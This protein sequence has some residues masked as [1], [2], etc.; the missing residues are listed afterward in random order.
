MEHTPQDDGSDVNYRLIRE[1]PTV[2]TVACPPELTWTNVAACLVPHELETELIKHAAI[3]GYCSGLLNKALSDLD[4]EISSEEAVLIA[5][6]KTSGL[7]GRDALIT[8]LARGNRR[9]PWLQWGAI[10]ASIALVGSAAIWWGMRAP[11]PEVLTAGVYSAWRTTELRTP[12]AKHAAMAPV[13]LAAS[14]S[15]EPPKEYYSAKAEILARLE[16]QPSDP[17]W[18]RAKGRMQSLD[19]EYEVAIKTLRRA[20]DNS[21]DDA[22]FA[23]SVSVDL[24]TA[25]FG[26]A[27]SLGKPD[28]FGEAYELL[29]EVIKKDPNNAVAL[30]NRAIV[31]E[32]MFLFEQAQKDLERFLVL[33][34]TGGWADEG[35]ERLAKLKA[36]GQ[37]IWKDPDPD[38]GMFLKNPAARPSEDYLPVAITGWLPML[39]GNSRDAALGALQS[40]AALM[41]T[42]HDDYWLNDLLRGPVG[43]CADSYAAAYVANREGKWGVAQQQG[44]MAKDCFGAA[45]NQAAALGARVELVTALNRTHMEKGP[46]LESTLSVSELKHGRYPWLFAQALIEHDSDARLADSSGVRSRINLALRTAEEHNFQT[47]R[48]RILPF[49]TT[50]DLSISNTAAVW[51]R[52]QE[53]LALYWNRPNPAIRSYNLLWNL[54]EAAYLEYR[55]LTALSIFREIIRLAGRIPDRMQEAIART[56]TGALAAEVGEFAE[57]IEHANAALEQIKK[58]PPNPQNAVY[59]LWKEVYLALFERANGRTPAALQRL[60]RIMRN[61]IDHADSATAALYYQFLAKAQLSEKMLDQASVS[62]SRA[63]E[64]AKGK[65]NSAETERD[66]LDWQRANAPVFRMQAAL[67]LDRKLDGKDAIQ[68]WEGY[69]YLTGSSNSPLMTG[70]VE[71]ELTRLGNASFIVYA[72]LEQRVAIWALNRDGIHFEWAPVSA[73]RIEQAAG[74]FERECSDP[75]SSPQELQRTGRELYAWLVSPIDRYLDGNG[76]L[77]IEADGLISAIPFAAL[78]DSEETYLSNT[79][80]IVYTTGLWAWLRGN[81]PPITVDSYILSIG[82]PSI[83]SG[84]SSRFPFLPGAIKEAEQ[85]AGMFRSKKLLIGQNATLGA[86]RQALPGAN[87]FHFAGHGFTYVEGGALLLASGAVLESTMLDARLLEGCRLA[88]LSACSSGAGERRGNAASDSLVRAFLRANVSNVIA[89][90]WNVDS[91]ATS[92]MITNFY[93]KLLKGAELGEALRSAGES[94]RHKTRWAHPYYWAGFSAYGRG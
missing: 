28:Q 58:V 66:R 16:K 65:L 15:L 41:I 35:R 56:R 81:A 20:Q 45:G 91:E 64:L 43:R 6:L 67:Q 73:A 29:S 3:C 7:Y 17:Y 36:R 94:N 30:F 40:L 32:S 83:A 50:A 80:A 21:P 34:P 93:S 72:I 79:R 53:G 76:S 10:A 24:A 8:E 51:K 9:R 2:R 57:A 37:M 59:D 42:E 62:L 46:F 84:H 86:I 23:A 85:V 33:E 44:R 47:L 19:R 70:R 63:I 78:R 14:S 54:G 55:S 31:G 89:S 22:G 61:D 68:S 27:R 5:Q 87:V 49:L 60:E 52:S 92:N 88:V 74:R 12:G 11:D 82:D 39:R 69:R 26:Q 48:L 18:L 1:G 25:Y 77:V 38:P 90:R 75:Q 4:P 71:D 13:Q